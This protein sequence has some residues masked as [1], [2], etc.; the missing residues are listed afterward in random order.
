MS[1][2][3][4]VNMRSSF[5]THKNPISNAAGGSRKAETSSTQGLTWDECIQQRLCFISCWVEESPA[6]G[7]CLQVFG[8][9]NPEMV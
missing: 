3:A 5:L 1:P 4:Y 8:Q 9:W 7:S 2:C 6:G